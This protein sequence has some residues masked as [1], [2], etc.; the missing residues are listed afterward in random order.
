[1]LAYTG[2]A[3]WPAE[4]ERAMDVN[5][6][7]DCLDRFGDDLSKWPEADRKAGE[8]FLATSAEAR[9][10]LEEAA[11]LREALAAQPVRAPSGLA[12]RILLQAK[13]DA[14][15]SVIARRTPV[16]VEKP[17]LW[18]RL[19]EVFPLALRP[20]SAFLLPICFVVGLLVGF[21][22]GS[23]TVDGTHLDLP[24]YVAHV[25]DTAHDAD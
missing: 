23:E 1:M 25:V 4:Q 16:A 22:S 5:L 9:D 20:S 12:D 21:F 10:L 3:A 15:P 2:C 8:A 13:L 6:F 7:E 18:A 17:S 19:G 11:L 24:S 14:A